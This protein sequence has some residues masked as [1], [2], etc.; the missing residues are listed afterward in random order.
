[1]FPPAEVLEFLEA[2]EKPRPI[3]LRTNTLKV[4]VHPLVDVVCI[5]TCLDCGSRLIWCTLVLLY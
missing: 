3:S 2:N 1:M 4:H 5:F